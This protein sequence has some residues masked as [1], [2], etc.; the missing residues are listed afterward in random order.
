MQTTTMTPT[1][2]ASTLRDT[3]VR[4][5]KG[6]DLGEVVDFMLDLESGRIRYAVLSFGGFLGMGDKLFAIPPQAFRV[7]VDNEDLILDVEKSVLESAP[8]FDKNDWPDFENPTWN[9]EV[10]RHYEITPYW[11]R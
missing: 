4:N 7:D 8:G 10:Y 6:E 5:A 3:K 1:L 2:S 9:V 11:N